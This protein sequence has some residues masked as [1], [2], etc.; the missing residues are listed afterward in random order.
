MRI[1]II[2]DSYPPMRSSAAVMLEDLAT[3]FQSN[4]HKPVVIVPDSTVDTSIVRSVINGV[5]VW[6]VS[7]PRTKDI[8][9]LRRTLSELYMP[10]VMLRHLRNSDFFKSTLDGVIWYSPSIFHGP[11]VKAL[12][13]ANDCKSY[14][15]LRDIF[16]EWAVNLGIMGRGLPYKFFKLVEAYQYSVADIIG[17]Q[18]PA[19]LA[20]FHKLG[21]SGLYQ[22]EVLHNWLSDSES[23][24]CTISLEKGALAGRKIFVYAGNMGKAQGIEP[25][26]EVIS[27]LD[28]IRDDI[29]FVFVGRGS[30]VKSLTKEITNR[31]LSNVLIFDEIKHNEISSLYAQCNFG[32]VFLDPRHRTHN[33]P[34]KF[35]SYMRYGVPVLACINEGN[36]LFEMIRDKRVGHAYIGADTNMVV[37]GVLEMADNPDYATE[38]PS[39]CRALAKGLFSSRVAIEQIIGSLLK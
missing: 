35:I 28:Q 22:V 5:E 4:G 31:N 16:P 17:V 34:G 14:L 9:Y 37:S 1:A 33:I 39:N 18:T 3:E 38:I 15:I 26:V 21:A 36:D 30:E 24:E 8:G 7:C 12:K 19:N 11:L 20:Y 32:L 25:F 13:K 10:F 6:R 29:G 2:A 23:A 27:K